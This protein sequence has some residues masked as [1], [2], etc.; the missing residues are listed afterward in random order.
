MC[1]QALI[2]DVQRASRL[3][4][5]PIACQLA[6]TRKLQ[7]FSDMSLENKVV[8]ITGASGGI[9]SVLAKLFSKHRSK[10]ALVDIDADGLR[11][12]AEECKAIQQVE[13]LTIEADL[14]IEEQL[15]DIAKQTLSKFSRVDVL[16]NNAGVGYQESIAETTWEHYNH[17]M[18]V[19]LRAPFFL[20][21]EFLPSLIENK[22]TI[23]N[24]SSGSG[25]FPVAQITAYSVSKAAVNHLTKNIAQD[26]AR[27][28]VRVNSVNPG[29]ADTKLTGTAE[30]P[31]L[32]RLTANV[33]QPISG[34]I[35]P[36]EIA[37]WIV[38]L[39]SEE[40]GPITGQ[41]ILV[42]GGK[43]VTRIPIDYVP[44]QLRD[45]TM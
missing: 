45:A 3:I 21:K 13:I 11:R 38:F 25:S 5:Y 4:S 1:L 12:V 19:N 43:E 39:A 9:G 20:T 7:H 10:L 2:C 15:K 18:N 31:S 36:E 34:L 32:V 33:M 16:V 27:H 42:D 30:K 29:A 6:S 23:I 26:V 37:R 24:T 44:K 40:S 17:V 8:V 35:K 28:G 41:N 14:T 22:G